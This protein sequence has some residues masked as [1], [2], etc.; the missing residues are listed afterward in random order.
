MHLL[1]I[2]VLS[3]QGAS[4]WASPTF[5]IPQKDDKVKVCWVSDLQEYKV[6]K[7]KNI[8]YHLFITKKRN[9]YQY[10]SKLDILMQYCTFEL[11]EDLKDVCTIVTPVGTFK[12]NRIPMGL[13]CSPDIVQ[14]VMKNIFC[15]IDDAELYIDDRS[16]F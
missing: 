12:Y 4:E 10:F 5:I 1:E 3:I 14:E 13:K 2:G 7:R 11:D 9:R 6:V 8:H 16:I 15:D